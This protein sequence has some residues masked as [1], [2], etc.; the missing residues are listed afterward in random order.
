MRDLV[1]N[2]D[3][4]CRNR[5]ELAP[6]LSGKTAVRRQTLCSGEC[7]DGFLQILTCLPVDFSGRESSGV[8]QD[9]RLYSQ[10]IEALGGVRALL[11]WFGRVDGVGSE[12]RRCS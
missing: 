3:W 11:A 9:L 4:F 1:L 2:R 10:R 8:Q 7:A 5:D 6:D 12:P